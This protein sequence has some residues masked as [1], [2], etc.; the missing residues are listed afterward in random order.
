M[1]QFLV[2]WFFMILIGATLLLYLVLVA[3]MIR[4]LIKDLF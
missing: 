2:G 4:H 3:V 1:I